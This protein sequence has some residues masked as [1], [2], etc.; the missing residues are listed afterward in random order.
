MAQIPTFFPGAE[1]FWG[2]KNVFY[3]LSTFSITSLRRVRYYW[4]KTHQQVTITVRTW[5]CERD[6]LMKCEQNKRGVKN[7]ICY[8]WLCE[9]LDIMVKKKEPFKDQFKKILQQVVML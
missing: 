4:G 8:P 5:D 7:Q 3:L 1:F 6:R 9:I 2:T